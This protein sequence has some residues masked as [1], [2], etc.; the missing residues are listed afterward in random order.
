M[1]LDE[2]HNQAMSLSFGPALVGGKDMSVEY[3]ACALCG[4]AGELANKVKK[5]WRGDGQLNREAVISEL[6]DVL[7]YA[8]YIAAALDTSLESV[9]AYNLAK[10]RARF[11][12][13]T[14]CGDGDHRERSA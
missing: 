2:Y 13:G 12:T 8:A 7:W 3:G 14:L 1:E 5:A 9:A 11:A 6:G 10:I 4:E